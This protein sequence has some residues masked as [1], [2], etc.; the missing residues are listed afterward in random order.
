VKNC[1]GVKALLKDWTLERIHALRDGKMMKKAI[2]GGPI[3]KVDGTETEP[4]CV[5]CDKKLPQD[6]Q[7]YV[8]GA[9]AKQ[10]VVLESQFI[11][12]ALEQKTVQAFVA[13]S[14]STARRDGW[15]F[16]F[17]TCDLNC[18]KSLQAAL[19]Q[20]TDVIGAVSA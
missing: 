2:V 4:F 17:M 1:P 6:T 18:A 9:T 19:R 15:D 20:E 5:W 12:L 16:V 7:V 3:K 14:G 10:K 11:P 13:A 8:L